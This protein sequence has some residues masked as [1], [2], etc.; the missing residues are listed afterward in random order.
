[1]DDLA[2]VIE[3]RRSTPGDAIGLFFIQPDADATAD[4]PTSVTSA[5]PA[6]SPKPKPVAVGE[7]AEVG[8]DVAEVEAEPVARAGP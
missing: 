2:S 3:I 8:R 6:P 7:Q 4:R 5:K 1:M